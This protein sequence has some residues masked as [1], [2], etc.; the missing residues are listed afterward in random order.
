MCVS[1]IFLA[2]PL[3]TYA[4]V[5][6][7]TLQ[8]AKRFY[9]THWIQVF[10][11]HSKMNL[12]HYAV[13]YFHYFGSLLVIIAHGPGFT[14]TAIGHKHSITL[15]LNQLNVLQY[16]AIAVFLYSLVEQHRC[17][18]TLA[19]LRKNKSGNLNLNPP[20]PIISREW[21]H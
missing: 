1:I 7:L 14:E 17:N 9:E 13:G 18:L 21:R 20:R 2:S 10:S 8:C 11:A 5:T 16:F 3:A 6:L 4:A 12:T 15:S 19:N